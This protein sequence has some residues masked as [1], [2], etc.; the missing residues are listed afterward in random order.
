[1]SGAPDIDALIGDHL[2]GVLGEEGRLRLEAWLAADPAH[3][4]RFLRLVMDH[5]ALTRLARAMA[6]KPPTLRTR[7]ILARR[8]RP[9]LAPLALAAGLLLALGAWWLW[10]G[11]SGQAITIEAPAVAIQPPAIDRQ[12]QL[13]GRR[14]AAGTRFAAD[15]AALLHWDDGSEIRLAPGTEVEIGSGLGL[16]LLRGRL[17]AV[18]A[19]QPAEQP[20]RFSTN[21]AMVTVVGTSL[22]VEA[23][24]G[25]SS[26][27]VRKGQVR[28]RRNANGSE[29][30]VGADE[31][32]AIAAGLDL[33]VRPLGS[34]A[35]TIHQVAAGARWPDLAR[36]QPGD[37][38]ELAAG[39]HTGAWRLPASGTAL[40]PIEVRGAG[41]EATCID[42]SG[43]STSGEHNGPRAVLQVDGRHV[44]ISGLT[45][46]G[47]RN[48]TANAAGLR[49][50][51]GADAIALRSCRIDGCDIG[52]FTDPGPGD[53]LVEDCVIVGNGTASPVRATHNLKLAN[54]SA[55][56]RGCRISD[57]HFGVNIELHDGQHR[58][59]GNRI[60]GGGEGE[61]GLVLN[62]A[63]PSRLDLVGNLVVGRTRAAGSN[64]DRFIYVNRPPGAALQLT[65]HGCTLVAGE[66]LNQMIDASG[67]EVMLSSS[68]VAGSARLA[69]PGTR[70]SGQDNCL[71]EQAD[72]A[73]LTRTKRDAPGFID[74]AAGDYRLLPGSPCRGA[75]LSPPPALEPP[76]VGTP[77]R[78]RGADGNIGAY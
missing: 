64:H 36:L 4:R 38:I 24:A 70:L 40:R 28:V 41:M 59:I 77:A 7:R 3:R 51:S 46:R 35:G 49:L 68:I 8:P 73:G 30:L 16:H 58:L 37:V 18:I 17:D 27:E 6:A 21:E 13:A 61:I 29:V 66:P 32:V 19:A 52:V 23:G 63:V 43:A 54:R 20:A 72:D 76:G 48:T 14:L 45:L 62:G 2:D 39:T 25:E 34:P 5:A 75:A 67:C 50:L 53:L 12:P 47:A 71:P 65:L 55:T 10:A 1:M 33:R 31:C 9:W 22:A 56:V 44:V 74:P 60:S 15:K 26:T 42:A 11:P 78:P 57:A 69:T